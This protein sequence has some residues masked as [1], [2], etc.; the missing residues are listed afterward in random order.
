[1][2]ANRRKESGFMKRK[3]PYTND[4]IET[5]YGERKVTMK[6]F[7]KILSKAIDPNGDW[8]T[9]QRL[10]DK[11]RY[12]VTDHKPSNKSWATIKKER[13]KI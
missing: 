11:Q 13:K 1:V 4:E 5:I 2:S 12:I 3:I 8:D 6:E 7:Q 9:V 10:V